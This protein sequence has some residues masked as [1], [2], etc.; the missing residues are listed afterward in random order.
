MLFARFQLRC[1][2]HCFEIGA[3]RQV[4]PTFWSWGSPGVAGWYVN[5]MVLS[6][7]SDARHPFEGCSVH[8]YEKIVAV[9]LCLDGRNLLDG[10]G[11]QW[12]AGTTTD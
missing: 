5:A 8:G 3:S 1:G 10:S 2:F 12:S 9:P 6:A 4:R 11:N 7:F